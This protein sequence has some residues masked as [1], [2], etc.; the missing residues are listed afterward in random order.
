MANDERLPVAGN[1][2]NGLII[3][4]A[5]KIEV[6]DRPVVDKLEAHQSTRTV[7][8][9]FFLY[10]VEI[11]TRHDDFVKRPVIYDR[12]FAL[13]LVFG[14][15]ATAPGADQRNQQRQQQKPPHPSIA[16]ALLRRFPF[17]RRRFGSLG[18]R[19]SLRF[20]FTHPAKSEPQGS[21][22]E[23]N[24]RTQGFQPFKQPDRPQIQP[25]SDIE[26]QEERNDNQ[27]KQ[28]FCRRKQIVAY[29][30]FPMPPLTARGLY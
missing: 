8:G 3:G 11:G 23:S 24:R 13:S 20:A 16:P 21:R 27:A 1:D 19:F 2:V 7:I 17:R 9:N 22:S 14:G 6:P 26:K 18:I 29:G 25:L 12:R 28:Q 4:H 30:E 15:R 5:F 10:A